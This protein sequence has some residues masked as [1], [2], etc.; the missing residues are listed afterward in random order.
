M[1]ELPT[2]CGVL[3]FVAGCW[4]DVISWLVSKECNSKLVCPV[5]NPYRQRG[6]DPGMEL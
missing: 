4:A 2:V 6:F 1:L 3:T 5:A